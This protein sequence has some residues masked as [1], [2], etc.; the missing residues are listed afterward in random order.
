MSA[1]ADSS[2]LFAFYV[3]R[4]VSARAV[5]KVQGLRESPLISSLVRYEVQQA[6]WFKVFLGANGHPLGWSEAEA[7]TTIATFELD[8]EKGLWA[9]GRVDWENVV[10]DAERLA[11]NHTPRHGGRTI[12]ILHL[13]TAKRLG[14][15][16]LLTFDRNQRRMAEAEGLIVS[17]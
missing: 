14:V 8:I 16:E 12:D 5:A 10:A 4:A 15:T 2:F 11:L 6:S 13:A 9:I 7:H 3:P 17:D 1:F